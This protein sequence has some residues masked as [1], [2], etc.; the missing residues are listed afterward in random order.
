MKNPKN[1]TRKQKERLKSLGM[2][3]KNWLIIREYPALEVMHRL[4]GKTRRLGA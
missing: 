4:S 2:I 3:P 1:P